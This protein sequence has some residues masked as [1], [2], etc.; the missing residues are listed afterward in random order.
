MRCPRNLSGRHI[1]KE[2]SAGWVCRCGKRRQKAPPRTG[3]ANE[4]A[5]RQRDRRALSRI[6]ARLLEAD[7]H[8]HA[9][10][11][12]RCE[13]R[14]RDI[15]HILPLGRGGAYLDPA[16]MLRV[17]RPCHE[18]ITLNPLQALER[19]LVKKGT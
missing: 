16:N 19:G 6:K 4:S 13:G 15:H 10:W 12:E 9:R 8:C 14:A 2:G 5:K 17:C 3:I 1:Y 11:D 18:A 7:P